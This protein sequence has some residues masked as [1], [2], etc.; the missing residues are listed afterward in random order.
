MYR[1]V[2]CLKM[3]SETA[4]CGCGV[5]PFIFFTVGMHLIGLDLVDL[6]IFSYARSLVFFVTHINFGNLL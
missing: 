3:S 2:K 5:S 1:T 6:D 4:L